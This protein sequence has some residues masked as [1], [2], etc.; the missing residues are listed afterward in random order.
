M[1]LGL[2]Y[3]LLF[4]ISLGYSVNDLVCDHDKKFVNNPIFFWCYIFYISK[5]HEL[6]DTV[7]I[8]VKKRK[9]TFLHLYHHVLT[10]SLSWLGMSHSVTHQW[11]A[12]VLNTC[13]HI[14]MYS[15]YMLS[16]FGINPWWKRY[17]TTGQMIQFWMNIFG[18]IYWFYLNYNEGCSGSLFAEVSCLFGQITFFILFQN[19]YNQTYKSKTLDTSSKHKE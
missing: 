5:Y 15:Y 19:F 10:L 8:V 2:V 18:I 6:L 13:I 14:F 7:F 11:I 12:A 17:L 9:L 16:T 3:E 1:F 4:N